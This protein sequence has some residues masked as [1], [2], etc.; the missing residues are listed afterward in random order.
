MLRDLV[1]LLGRKFWRAR[2]FSE[3]DVCRL[4][5]LIGRKSFPIRRLTLLRADLFL[6]AVLESILGF[7]IN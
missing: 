5:G 4:W 1:R 7:L 2:S 6:L 3:S